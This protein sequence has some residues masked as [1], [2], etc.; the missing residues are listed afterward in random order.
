MIEISFD[1]QV[2]AMSI[3]PKI[4]V[5]ACLLGQPVRYNGKALTRES[6]LIQSWAEQGMIVSLC[7]EIA[8]G[9]PVPRP[10]AEIEVGY[11][12]NNVIGGHGRI[13]ENTNADVTERML[14]GAQIALDLAKNENCEYA[15]LTDGSPS[16][17]ATFIY[18]GKHDGVRRAGSGVVTALLRKEGIRVFAQHEITKLAVHL[19]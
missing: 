18:S 19:G 9:F 14:G 13:Y 6:K 3:T 11:E 12:G 4:L 15:L 2:V 1:L 5:S 8:A 16:C 17:G 7:P 10:P